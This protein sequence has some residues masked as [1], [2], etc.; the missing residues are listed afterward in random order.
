MQ[1]S[2]VVAVARWIT[3]DV[4]DQSQVQS[5][6]PNHHNQIPIADIGRRKRVDTLIAPVCGGETCVT[7]QPCHSH[8]IQFVRVLPA[9]TQG[10]VHETFRM[11]QTTKINNYPSY[12]ALIRGLI[13]GAQVV[14]FFRPDGKC[15]WISVKKAAPNLRLVVK[16]VLRTA[17]SVRNVEAEEV[18]FA[19][20]LRG[21]RGVVG[22]VALSVSMSESDNW[23][24]S[25]ARIETAL[26][27]VV[28]V[29]TH[30]LGAQVPEPKTK[31]LTERTEE[32]EWLF[33]VTSGLRSGSSESAAVEQLLAAAV[34]RMK[35]SYG[36]LAVTEK[37]LNVTYASPTRGDPA[38]GVAYTQAQPHLMNF[39]Q[40]QKKPMVINKPA[41]GRADLLKHKI[42]A[43]PILQTGK[44]AGLLAFYRPFDNADFGRREQYLGRHIARQIGALLDSQYD[45]ATGL[46]T[47]VAFEQQVNQLLTGRPD[48]VHSLV[49]IDIDELNLVNEA[50]GYEAGDELILRVAE[51]LRPPGLPADAIAARTAGDRFLLFLPGYD[52]AAAR[53]CAVNLQK[54]VAAITVGAGSRRLTVSFSCGTS[55]LLEIDQ[56]VARAI[57]A[58]ELA[59][60]T[61]KERG[62][63]RCEVYLDV[64]ESMM[65]RR[66]DITGLGKLRDA[67]SHDR[68]VL[69]GHR[70]APIGDLSATAA[71]ECLVC[72]RNPDGTVVPTGEL[73]STAQ[74]FKLLKEIDEWGIKNA[75]RMLAPHASMMLHSG[76]RMVVNISGE[77]LNDEHLVARIAEWVRA[78]KVP[79][80]RITF[81][82]G[83]T[84]A[85][86][87]LPLANKLM[88]GLRQMGCRF[89]LDGFGTGV[90]SLSYLK[91]LPVHSV[92]IDGSYVRDVAT[93]PRSAAMVRAIVELARELDIESVAD[94]VESD[95]VLAKLRELGVDFVQGG[96]IHQP[97][98][99]KSF[100][101]TEARA[102]SQVVR[103]VALI[104]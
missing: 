35:A 14:G 82:V 87:N 12:D 34:E 7:A 17:R 41:P 46:Y 24:M 48:R 51:S 6:H 52:A 90:N 2:A 40:R 1:S 104:D 50:F 62:R 61:A 9:T 102:A 19:L 39:V 70:I 33:S 38:A 97:E 54:L 99:L 22:I 58:A 69:Y 72:M 8:A 59:C 75:L 55:R 64:D 74:R 30:E 65:R 85:V 95:A 29:L 84:A 25:L 45:L 103:Q 56:P 42:L 66:I 94:L 68:F 31:V 60:K 44:V 20:P 91:C 26:Q 67:L 49:Y 80:G 23:D 47:R 13:A 15:V 3:N 71:L 11:S 77:S 4:R 83:E 76:M 88:S 86:S 89:A 18:S 101:D 79:P 96:R 10:L 43:V 98:D 5:C 16:E 81:E 78:S 93:N 36:G 63:N 27:P 57:A 73:M 37:R 53:E 100:L 32:L 21:K 92:K 28:T